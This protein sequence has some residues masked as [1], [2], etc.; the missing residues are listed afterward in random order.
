M[1]GLR[2][3]SRDRQEALLADSEE[4]AKSRS[5]ATLVPFTV[6]PPDPQGSPLGST[7]GSPHPQPAGPRQIAFNRHELNQILRVYGRMVAAG[8][9]RDYAIDHLKEKAVFSIFRRTAEM[10]LYRVEKD[11]SLARRQG[12]Y[13]VIAAGGYVMKRGHDLHQVLSVLDKKLKL[14]DG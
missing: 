10:P 2:H 12:A 14:V 5:A 4:E 13:A 7:S 8:E 9:W 6:S 3:W 1:T 11:P